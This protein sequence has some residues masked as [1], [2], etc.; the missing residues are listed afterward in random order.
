LGKRKKKRKRRGYNLIGR[1]GRHAVTD[2]E[3]RLRI[4][5]VPTAPNDA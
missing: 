1:S 5:V 2:K 3:W 4:L